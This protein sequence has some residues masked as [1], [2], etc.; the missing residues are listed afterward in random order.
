MRLF[1]TVWPEIN[2]F[3]FTLPVSDKLK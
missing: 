1:R 2:Y 3:R